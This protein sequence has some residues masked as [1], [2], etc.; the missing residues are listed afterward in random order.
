[1]RLIKAGEDPHQLAS[2]HEFTFISFYKQS[3]Q[4]SGEGVVL[5]FMFEEAIKYM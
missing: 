4:E 1:M 5:Q 3:E 2:Q